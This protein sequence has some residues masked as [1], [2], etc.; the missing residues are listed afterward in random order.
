MKQYVVTFFIE[1]MVPRYGL[2]A[3]FNNRYAAD[4]YRLEVAKFFDLEGI[5][6]STRVDELDSNGYPDLQKLVMES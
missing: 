6:G 1:D 4:K 2:L 5:L 3:S